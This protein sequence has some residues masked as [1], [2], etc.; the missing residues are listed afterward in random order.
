LQN[1]GTGSVADKH[2]PRVQSLGVRN[3]LAVLLLSLCLAGC[4]RGCL[5]GARM[6]TAPT[7]VDV[8]THAEWRHGH[9]AGSRHLPLSE[10]QGRL[11][12]LQDLRDREVLT[13]CAG[14]ARAQTA[15]EILRNA[16]FAH[17]S[18]LDGG[19]RAWT[20]PLEGRRMDADGAGYQERF[21]VGA[22]FV[23]KEQGDDDGPAGLLVET[24]YPGAF[25][26]EVLQYGD[27][28]TAID[29]VA[30]RPER[31]RNA[32]YAALFPPGH[33]R[34]LLRVNGKDRSLKTGAA[35]GAKPAPAR[36]AEPELAALH[37]WI[38]AN[39]P[40]AAREAVQ[41]AFAP[42][43]QAW[44]PTALPWAAGV[45]ADPVSGLRLSG[46][47]VSVPLQGEG[48]DEA[49]TLALTQAGAWLGVEVPAATPIAVP[50]SASDLM[51]TI[52]SLVMRADQQ[53]HPSGVQTG[54]WHRLLPALVEHVFVHDQADD[55]TIGALYQL[56]ADARTF[57]LAPSL[58]IALQMTQLASAAWL[59]AAK[60]ALHGVRLTAASPG[61][62]GE[63]I[64]ARQTPSGMIVIGGAG[65][66]TYTGR[67]AAIV[68]V[69]GDD[70]YELPTG[71]TPRLLID[72]QGRDS[73]RI[74]GEL[75]PGTRIGGARMA[76]DVAGDD[77]YEAQSFGLGA[78]MFGVSV[79]ADLGGDDTY[80]AE[81]AALGAGLWGIGLLVDLSGND[82]YT[83]GRLTQGAGGP[84]GAGLLLDGAGDDRYEAVATASADFPLGEMAQGCGMGVR[85]L[86]FGGVGMLW[87]GAGDDQYAG[88]EYVQGVGY[89]GGMGI[90]IDRAGADRYRA[91]KY[92][93]AAGVH[94]GIGL[95]DDGS[96]DDSYDLLEQE[97]GQSVAW[98]MG[99]SVL[100]DRGGNDRYAAS[101][102]A[103]AYAA[104]N[105][106]ALF[107]DLEGQDS[108]ACARPAECQGVAGPNDYAG[109]R[110]APSLALHYG[111]RSPSSR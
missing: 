19:M 46:R 10:L 38:D 65:A 45:L 31:L 16:G 110:G 63:V 62:T 111:R 71:E 24:A 73:Y 104:Q 79:Q 53:A 44:A 77:T 4:A 37:A 40:Q 70:R 12:E 42:H 43:L 93:Q 39:T 58:G 83:G 67:F 109:G 101:G 33:P 5:H 76:L 26:G 3:A 103:Q 60:K 99:V 8:R 86:A 68:D 2:G 23:V 1:Q 22:S 105:G 18:V 95:L 14:G 9:I 47:S 94:A 36:A 6:Q 29:G 88:D 7:Y 85:E 108:Y 84:A 69:A 87:D 17:V 98:D 59:D 97:R 100:L 51:D 30:L 89:F 56:A 96:G 81:S 32:S 28:V 27:C 106:V 34:Y 25:A 74:S 82:R 55:A 49:T 20:G 90:L 107:A 50:R 35:K 61:V 72:L 11:G 78:G 64:A 91:R 52:E 15:A 57:A 13:V 102:M 48:G 92:A 75:S 41:A 66:N 80:R 54:A 21:R